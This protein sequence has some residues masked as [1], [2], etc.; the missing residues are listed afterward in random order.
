MKKFKLIKNMVKMEYGYNYEIKAG[1]V[2]E[3]ISFNKEK[4]AF[5]LAGPGGVVNFE[6]PTEDLDIW[7]R[8]LED[9]E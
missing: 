8:F 9:S 2:V 6:I 5:K 7:G 4:Y 3:C 1:T